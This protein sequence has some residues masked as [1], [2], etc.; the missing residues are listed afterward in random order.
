MVIDSASVRV[1]KGG[2]HAGLNSTNRGKKG[3]KRHI[4]TDANGIPLM[5]RTGPAN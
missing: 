5:V 2:A 4:V 1:L 3:Y